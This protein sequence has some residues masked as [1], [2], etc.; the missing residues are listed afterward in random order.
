MLSSCRIYQTAVPPPVKYNAGKVYQQIET[1]YP[2]IRFIKQLII[3][4]NGE[5]K[6]HSSTCTS[7]NVQASL[8]V[9]FLAKF[10]RTGTSQFG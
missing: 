2:L 3:A 4:H 9:R 5:K 10:M 6:I 8:L 7:D 1:F